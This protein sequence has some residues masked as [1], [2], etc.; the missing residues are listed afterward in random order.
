R[1]SPNTCDVWPR[2]YGVDVDDAGNVYVASS[3]FEVVTEFRPDG[4]CVK[5]FGQ[6]GKGPKQL[7]QLRRVAVG[8]GSNPLVYAADL[9]GLKIL[10]FN[11]DGTLSNSRPEIGNGLY[12]A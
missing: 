7:F 3:N 11:Q 5:T 8:S 4:S 2:P 6:K 10:T 1:G 12:P 9:W